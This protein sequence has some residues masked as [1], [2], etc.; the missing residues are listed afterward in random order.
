MLVVGLVLM[1][2][3]GGMGF[4][5]IPSP[6]RNHELSRKKPDVDSAWRKKGNDSYIPLFNEKKMYD[7][8]S[9]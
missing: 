7:K 5:I 2:F 8:E 4:P 1:M 3:I 6:L 9:S